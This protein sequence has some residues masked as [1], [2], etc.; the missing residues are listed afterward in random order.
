MV[1]QGDIVERVTKVIAETL[2]ID[3]AKITRESR[4]VE[5]LGADSLDRMTLVMQL[6]EEFK[7]SITD[8]E[9]KELASVG[10]VVDFIVKKAAEK[11]A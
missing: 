11:A 2:N 4:F 5:D 3:R 7:A 8:E 6:E 9:A 10:A 1:E